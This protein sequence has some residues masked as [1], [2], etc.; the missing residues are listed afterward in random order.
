MSEHD[1]QD[2]KLV[3]GAAQPDDLRNLF[4]TDEEDPLAQM[5]DDPNYG[6]LIKELEYIAAE[7]R[8]LFDPV[9][10]DPSDKVWEGIQKELG[11]PTDA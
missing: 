2:P 9:E 1:E 10:E 8:R 5:R 3:N 6:A 7:A 4:A 11:K